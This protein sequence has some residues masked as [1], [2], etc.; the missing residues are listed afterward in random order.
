[1]ELKGD[2]FL[3]IIFHTLDCCN[4]HVEQTEVHLYT[5][6]KKTVIVQEEYITPTVMGTATGTHNLHDE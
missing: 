6:E 4:I 5:N 2:S 3:V 1:M